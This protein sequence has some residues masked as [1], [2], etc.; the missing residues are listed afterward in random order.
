MERLYPSA[1]A[2]NLVKNKPRT[3]DELKKR[4][5]KWTRMEKREKGNRADH[6]QDSKEKKGKSAYQ[7]PSLYRKETKDM[8]N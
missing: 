4:A 8:R 3:M 6:P 1:F 7:G 5:R 2:K